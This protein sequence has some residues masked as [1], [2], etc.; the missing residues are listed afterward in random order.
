VL[1][2]KDA[3]RDAGNSRELVTDY[4]E[5]QTQNARRSGAV[6]AVTHAVAWTI[7]PDELI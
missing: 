3:G 6:V 1:D 2:R 4:C 5:R 7:G